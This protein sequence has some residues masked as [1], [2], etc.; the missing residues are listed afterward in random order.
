MKKRLLTALL[1]VCC[2]CAAAFGI[3]GC[4]EEHEHTYSSD[5][6]YNET[7]HWHA[8]TCV[9]TDEVSD[10][11][12]H[13]T[14]GTDG[15]CSVCGYKATSNEPTEH[16]HVWSEWE[17]SVQP[18]ETAEGKATRTCSGTGTCDVTDNTQTYTLPVLTDSGYTKTAETA[19]TCTAEGSVTYS[20]NKDG[21]EVSFTASTPLDASA[22]DYGAYTYTDG[23][24]HYKVCSYNPAHKTATEPHD[25]DGADGA[26][27]VCGYK[28]AETPIEHTHVWSEWEVT[29]TP[30]ETAAGSATRTCSGTGT[31]DVTDNTQTYT[32]PV[33]T[34]S[35]YTKTAETDATCAEAGT[36]TY[37]YQNGDI[38]ITV[39]T[40]T[41]R[42]S[43]HTLVRHDAQAAAE[44]EN[45]NV[46]YWVCNACNSYFLDADGTNE[47]TAEK[48]IVEALGTKVPSFDESVANLYKGLSDPDQYGTKYSYT[49]TL[50]TDGTATYKTE[51]STGKYDVY[52]YAEGSGSEYKYKI[53]VSVSESGYEANFIIK[54]NINTDG[55][56]GTVTLT[57]YDPDKNVQATLSVP[58]MQTLLP[59][60]MGTLT[61]TTGVGAEFDTYKVE[62]AQGGSYI[63]AVSS[64]GNA[65]GQALGSIE[66][67]V[68]D[69]SGETNTFNT[70]NS[71]SLI[72][73][74]DATSSNFDAQWTI[75]LSQGVNY[76]TVGTAS[77]GY[78]SSAATA[79]AVFLSAKIVSQSM[80]VAPNVPYDLATELSLSNATYRPTKAD[81]VTV[82]D[83]GVLT[84]NEDSV[85]K[86]LTL[87]AADSG[88]TYS[89][90]VTIGYT[91]YSVTVSGDAPAKINPKD[92]DKTL[93]LAVDN[94]EGT[95]VVWSIDNPEETDATVSESGLLTA[96]S[97]TGVAI[98][99]ATVK[100]S[101]GYVIG[102]GSIQV[103]ISSVT[104]A[105]VFT[106]S[107]VSD[108]DKTIA[109]T[110][111]NTTSYNGTVP[112]S[113]TIP[114]T[115]WYDGT[116]AYSEEPSD[117]ENA[118]QYTVT[119]IAS[120]AS[121]SKGA[122]Y[123]KT[124]LTEIEIPST[125][126]SIGDYAFYKCTGLTSV[127]IGSGVTSIGANAFYQC[128]ALAEITLPESVTRIGAS[129]F[130]S[131]SKLKMLKL[132][133]LNAWY[134]VTI[135]T[136]GAPLYAAG[137]SVYVKNGEDYE[138]LTSLNIPESV[139]SI[140]A[141]QF[142]NWKGIT[143][144][145][146]KGSVTE[147]GDY[148]FNGCSALTAITLPESVTSIGA[149]AFASCSQL[150]TLK[151]DNLNAWYS[152]TIGSNGAPLYA[153]GGSV[154]VKSGDD[155][156]L[157][158]SLE[159]PATVTA[160]GAYRFYKWTGITTVT[161][162]GD[163]TEIGANAFNGCSG[164]TAITLPDSV[165]SI[166][167]YAFSGCSGLTG[168]SISDNVESLGNYVF[169]SCTGLTS[170]TIG[171]GVKSIGNYA[172]KGCTSLTG[173]SIPDTVESIGTYAFQ[174]CTSLASV[175][176]GSGVT[177]IGNYAFNKCT[178]LTAVDIPD[179]VQTI[180]NS[181]FEGCTKLATLTIGKGVTGIG[182]KAFYG[183]TALT[184]LYYNAA[185]CGDCT[186]TLASTPF[187]QAGYKASGLTVT[188]GANVTKIPAY[189]FYN[190]MYS[191]TNNI[192]I[193]SLVWEEN[194]QCT[195]IGK[196]AFCYFGTQFTS[197]TIPESVTTIGE[198]A[199]KGNWYVTELYYNATNCETV[200][201]QAFAV[202]GDDK[203]TTVTI[204][205]NVTA[206]P[207]NLFYTSDYAH[208]VIAVVFEGTSLTSIGANAFGS[209]TANGTASGTSYIKNVYYKGTAEQWSALTSSGIGSGNEPLTS[210]TVYYY[211]AEQPET[212]G[213]YWHYDEGGKVTVWEAIKNEEEA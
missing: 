93:Q 10:K 191:A 56:D 119:A 130:A 188:I 18:T 51:S 121:Y 140:G 175:T 210:A 6:S 211:S 106:W 49:L 30:T 9:H 21:V 90:T 47:T 81:L 168:I 200:S 137:G 118:V 185:A 166:G 99:K 131:C 64:L 132:D 44:T 143:E 89:L 63:F 40:W 39:I 154:Y 209:C 52:E 84:A 124:A 41:P 92:D 205:E 189:L 173:I 12:A 207:A 85:G 169:Q 111:Y 69:E 91:E 128:S 60:Q 42:T 31:C 145:T 156:E 5:W 46:E 178:A 199:F 62:S 100:N 117:N 201:S 71:S 149:S 107:V 146:F 65:N 155:Y 206:L 104:D 22:H 38:Q 1:S 174:S 177:S 161:F 203:G 98:V 35:G 159:V 32:L 58:E 190:G 180:G 73:N 4:G 97:K 43:D 184:E 183:C 16:T 142:Y 135:G 164:L 96:G 112:T 87:Y 152:V 82:T 94:E 113:I 34:D 13:D 78:L 72:W 120:A 17:V 66:I 20:Y 70:W 150:K 23:T 187:Y 77:N 76:I 101:D 3:A 108:T 2:L 88:V 198:G 167:D 153:A 68:K 126:T 50:N 133:N 151:L 129:A 127:T 11:A 61:V 193:T 195:D 14:D 204:G 176:I 196:Y 138:E 170:V 172:F 163:V 136:S 181:A 103:N 115:I 122:F 116:T 182:T 194:S 114:E 57:L 48:V 162:L 26:C 33:L 208:E 139:T 125:V 102:Y 179:N 53:N 141:N 213:N 86:S 165:T 192:Y 202:I 105:N 134:G 37:S 148:A 80:T 28:A 36:V 67:S 7:Y 27:S 74:G 45:G 171:S 25:T 157:L 144:V 186:S 79:D 55:E 109:L 8:A 19:A 160:I 75:T 15:A 197:L 212:E 29:I 158:T 110:G 24:G 95:S 54:F 59:G 123:N 147:I 83:A